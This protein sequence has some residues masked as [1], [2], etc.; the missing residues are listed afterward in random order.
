MSWNFIPIY[1]FSYNI[2]KKHNNTN[3]ILLLYTRKN[4]ADSGWY[5]IRDN[6][7]VT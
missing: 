3:I 1:E 7:N 2:I 5:F 6:S 4:K